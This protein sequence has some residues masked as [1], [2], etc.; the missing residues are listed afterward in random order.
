MGV[1]Q[2]HAEQHQGG[3]DAAEG[4]LGGWLRKWRHDSALNLTPLQEILTAARGLA[5]AERV[6]TDRAIH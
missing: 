3:G 6:G 2:Q 1:G 5:A 4:R